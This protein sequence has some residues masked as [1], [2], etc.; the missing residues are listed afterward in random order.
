MRIRVPGGWRIAAAFALQLPIAVTPASAQSVP[1]P[2]LSPPALAAATEAEDITASIARNPARDV[3]STRI[4]RSALTPRD[5]GDLA[6]RP[7][8]RSTA[9]EGPS[10]YAAT[11]I[12][13][14]VR[15]AIVPG[16]NPRVHD[17]GRTFRV[18]GLLV[19][20]ADASLEEALAPL[21][22]SLG[23]APIGVADVFA[24]AQAVQN[25]LA[26]RGDTLRRVIIPNQDLRDGATIRLQ[27]LAP[28]Y[29]GLD[30]DGLPPRLRPLF[31]SRLEP[32][33]ATGQAF[34]HAAFDRALQSLQEQVGLPVRASPAERGGRRLV[35]V[36]ASSR[37]VSWEIGAT[38]VLGKP[39]HGL[40]SQAGVVLHSPFGW[41]ER[42]Y[43]LIHAGRREEFDLYQGPSVM[44]TAGLSL[45]LGG[46][47]ASLD[48]SY[49]RY[50]DV[51][52]I[53]GAFD[54]SFRLIT[55]RIAVRLDYPLWWTRQSRLFLRVTADASQQAQFLTLEPDPQAALWKEETRALRLALDLAH[56]HPVLGHFES[57]IELS[58]GFSGLGARS[59][60]GPIPWSQPGAKPDF[61][62]VDA[63]M[64]LRSQIG[65]GFVL[66]LAGRGQ[67]SLG[68]ALP[69]LEQIALLS[70]GQL[71]TLNL[72]TAAGESGLV[73]QAELSRPVELP[74]A[75]GIVQG[76]T[77]EPFVVASLGSVWSRAPLPGD[78]TMTTGHRVGGGF[79]LLAPSSDGARPFEL[80]VEASRVRTNGA[81]QEQTTLTLNALA[82]F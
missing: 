17:G 28:A 40:L 42:V 47:G 72:V 73:A 14:G 56:M 11:M 9:S 69:A 46:S 23:S 55:D 39:A 29:A 50:D 62:K 70:F 30:L 34:D 7:A 22:T 48:L 49:S 8:N 53:R 20:G 57:N 59:T 32:L 35:A 45:P 67:A 12:R 63:R 61:W 81:V 21:K 15:L 71:R 54:D 16:T 68:G 66:E 19:A 60:R 43:G 58:R 44:G 33:V 38:S 27:I 52:H 37:L 75:F 18:G 74:A 82:R 4:V 1:A 77:L 80:G 5:G 10:T 31:R 79:R 13:N 25:A 36:T 78:R 26:G 24:A 76:W 51:R 3:R 65:A 41:G 6:R 2:A 64:K